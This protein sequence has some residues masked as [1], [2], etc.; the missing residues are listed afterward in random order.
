MKECGNIF[1]IRLA[2]VTW[3]VLLDPKFIEVILSSN[4]LIKKTSE[5]DFF[6]GWLGNG[7]LLS[8]GKVFTYSRMILIDSLHYVLHFRCKMAKKT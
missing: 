4:K 8:T 6:K 1:R 5:Y 3:L 2:A 7:L